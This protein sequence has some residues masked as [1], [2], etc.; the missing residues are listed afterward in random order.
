LRPL[1]TVV[2]GT[3]QGVIALSKKRSQSSAR[4]EL[5]YLGLLLAMLVLGVIGMFLGDAT[6]YPYQEF[7]AI[8]W[9]TAVFMTFL[10]GMLYYALFVLPIAGGE[11]WTEGLR[12][13]TRN[14]LSPPPKVDDSRKGK[15]KKAKTAV[16][17]E[18]LADLPPSF[19]YLDSGMVPSHQVLAV[20]KRGGFSR[21]A[22]PGF[23]VLFKKELISQIIDLRRHSRT[24]VVKANTRDGIPIEFPI[25]VNFQVWQHQEDI[26]PGDTVYHYDPD[27]IFHVNYAGSVVD[28]ETASRWSDLVTPI[29]ANL[30]VTE[31][32]RYTL[33]Q[34]Y[35]ADSDGNGPKT[36]INRRVQRNLERSERL[37]GIDILSVNS[38]GIILPESVR[39]QRIK[40]WQSQWQREIKMRNAKVDAE[41]ELRLKH[42]R[43]RAQIEI[44][45][46]IT[47]SIIASSRSGVS[48]TEIVALRMIEAMEEA[49]SDGSVQAL[50]P[51][52]VLTTM[53]ESSRQML[54][55]LDEEDEGGESR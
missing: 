5:G 7:G 32:A 53:V 4:K 26:R 13:L 33:D 2:V 1:L 37:E 18:H 50:V 29:A 22:G 15:R 42:A 46:K 8:W 28:G 52:P 10:V 44:I 23:V 38:G 24:E 39:E 14:F 51:R 30:Y 55:W 36:E 27:G 31:I 45:Q 16:M 12:L 40:H 35:E 43:A 54:N 20:V 48:V 19:Y 21:P 9:A 47:Q 17:P 11:G 25:F 3:F 49:V 41:A 6:G 34:L